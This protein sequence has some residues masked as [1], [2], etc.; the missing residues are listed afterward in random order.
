MGLTDE[1]REGDVVWWVFV[2]RRIRKIKFPPAA[3]RPPPPP[4]LEILRTN[5]GETA[6][7][8]EDDAYNPLLRLESDHS[9]LPMPTAHFLKVGSNNWDDIVN[10]ITPTVWGRNV[11]VE[12]TVTGGAVLRLR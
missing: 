6:Y 5:R 10:S 8:Y 1:S 7:C 12:A 2:S 3:N 9:S 4:V 11:E